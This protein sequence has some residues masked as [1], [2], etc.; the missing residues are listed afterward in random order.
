MADAKCAA[1]C[2]NTPPPRHYHNAA[3]TPPPVLSLV[4]TWFIHDADSIISFQE[5]HIISFDTLLLI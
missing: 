2:G 1:L 5:F 3:A 4:G